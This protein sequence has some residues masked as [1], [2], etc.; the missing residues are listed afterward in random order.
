MLLTLFGFYELNKKMGEMDKRFD[1]INM[2]ISQLE[3][4]AGTPAGQPGQ[5]NQDRANGAGPETTAAAGSVASGDR[6]EGEPGAKNNIQT[7]TVRGGDTWW[8]ISQKMYNNGNYYQALS[9]YNNNVELNIGTVISIPPVE[10][11]KD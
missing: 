2:I 11:L 10:D 3:N 7:Y 9:N 4:G 5:S 1:N 8:I 6:L